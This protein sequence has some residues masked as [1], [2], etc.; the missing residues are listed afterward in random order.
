MDDETKELWQQCLAMLQ[1]L[2]IDQQGLLY[3]IFN[4]TRQL[5]GAENYYIK[6]IA[7]RQPE[8]AAHEARNQA[9]KERLV[10]DVTAFLAAMQPVLQQVQRNAAAQA[11]K[12]KQEE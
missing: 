5:L 2:R 9:R 8:F 1:D 7:G 3:Q 12:D 10:D 11:A 6:Y 4:R